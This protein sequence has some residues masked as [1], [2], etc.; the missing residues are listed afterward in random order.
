MP[1]L[2]LD[3]ANL[4]EIGKYV[5]MGVV[6]GVTTNPS[7]VSKEAPGDYLERIKSFAQV[8]QESTRRP[9]HLSVEVTSLDPD[10]MVTEAVEIKDVFRGTLGNVPFP[11]VNLYIK[12][13]II[14]EAF[15]VIGKLW[16]AWSISVN[17]TACMT[18]PQ[19]KLAADAGASVVS[20]FWNRIRDGGGHPQD[21][22]DRYKRWQPYVPVICGSIRTVHDVL[23][24][25]KAGADIVTAKAEIIDQLLHHPQTDI[26]VKKFQEDIERWRS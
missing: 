24:G 18:A 5:R 21:E 14:P 26:A 7:L 10:K 1:K 6:S 13:P 2:F 15:P 19:G 11:E 23:F 16:N 22:I 25:W 12:I 17:A 3:S 9:I 4:D 8:I 20:F